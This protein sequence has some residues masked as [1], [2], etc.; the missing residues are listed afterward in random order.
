MSEHAEV[1]DDTGGQAQ[2]DAG[3]E[4]AENQGAATEVPR[5]K[6]HRA[7]ADWRSFV[8]DNARLLITFAVLA[9]GVVFV[10]LGWYGAAHTNILTEQIPYLISGGLLGLGLIIVAGV[11]AAGAAQERTTDALRR[12]IA[13]AL[14]NISIGA[15]DAGVR[16]NAFSSN[17]H[18]VYVVPGG[19]SFHVAG[20]PILE[21]KEGIKELQPAQAAEAGYVACKLCGE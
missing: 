12:E 15:P 20:C 10:I 14:A 9:A 18:G 8:R 3:A 19:R 11:M 6:K 13:T 21:G 7:P 4:P 17:G 1:S 2:A 16:S 5:A